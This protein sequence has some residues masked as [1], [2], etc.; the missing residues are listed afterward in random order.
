MAIKQLDATNLLCPMP[1]IK[2]QQ[3]IEGMNEGDVLEVICTDPGVRYDIP[4]WV[5]IHGHEVIETNMEQD[6]EN[7]EQIYFKVKVN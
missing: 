3:A 1:V 7:G 4:A 6:L 5:R 2:T